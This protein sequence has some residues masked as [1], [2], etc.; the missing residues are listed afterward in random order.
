MRPALNRNSISHVASLASMPDESK[1][2]SLV[3]LMCV[4]TVVCVGLYHH[5][6]H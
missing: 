2:P 6:I 5:N 3:S 4:V 1:R